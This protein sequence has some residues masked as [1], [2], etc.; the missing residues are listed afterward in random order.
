MRSSRSMM[1]GAISHMTFTGRWLA[2]KSPPYTV[3]SKCCQVESPSPFRFLAALMPPCAQTECERFTGTIENRS[4][5]PPISAI[6][7]TAAS[8][9]SPPPT[10][11]IFGAAA[12]SVHPPSGNNCPGIHNVSTGSGLLE[13]RAECVQASE[14]DDAHKEEEC[15]ANPKQPLLC[16]FAGNNAPLRREE[17]DSV[18]KVP[19]CGNQSKDVENEQEGGM[20]FGLYL[21]E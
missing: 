5:C 15:E 13:T 8:P 9:A 16:F 2:R 1:P 4:T 11:M 12:I 21:P 6:L 17:P 20:D 3:S 7:M 10:T 18:G 19:G 14:S